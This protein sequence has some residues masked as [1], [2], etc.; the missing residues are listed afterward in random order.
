MA[1]S[2]RPDEGSRP[3]HIGNAAADQFQ[4]DTFGELAMQN[5]APRLS[6]T[7]GQVRWTGPAL[8]QHNDEVYGA[9][10]GLSANEIATLKQSGII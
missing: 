5:V 2:E 1:R 10:L 9:W 7:P 4:L 6:D 3:V 8:G